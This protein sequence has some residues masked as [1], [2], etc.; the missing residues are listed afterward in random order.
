VA[1]GVDE[2]APG[3]AGGNWSGAH[4]SAPGVA[5]AETLGAA[6]KRLNE[7]IRSAESKRSG[8]PRR[9]DPEW[10]NVCMEHDLST[11]AAQRAGEIG[12]GNRRRREPSD[13]SEGRREVYQS[14]PAI[15]EEMY[16][17]YDEDKN[18]YQADA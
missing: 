2:V 1:A 11:C 12:A 15:C 6:I 13:T 3:V 16:D 9:C 18:E 14:H 17:L 4:D 8:R 10:N 7:L 5:C